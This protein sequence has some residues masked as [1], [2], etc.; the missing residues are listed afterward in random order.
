MTECFFNKDFI[1]LDLEAESAFDV[2][3]YGSKLLYDAGYV[4]ETYCQSVIDRE[5]VAPTGLPTDGLFVAMPHTFGEHVLKEG[6]VLIR[7]KEP[8]IFKSMEDGE[9]DLPVKIVTLLAFNNGESQMKHLMELMRLFQ[10]KELLIKV[11]EANT[12]DEVHALLNS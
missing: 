5:L 11:N 4:K 3:K 9:T 12:A 2:I 10:N 7:V 6:A 1:V 8:V